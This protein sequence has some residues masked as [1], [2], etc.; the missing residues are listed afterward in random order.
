[1]RGRH[2]LF[3][4]DDRQA[5]FD[6]FYQQMTHG[7]KNDV[8]IVPNAIIKAMD[9]HNTCGVFDTNLN[10]VKSAEIRW[11]HDILMYN[12]DASGIGATPP[13]C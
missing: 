2:I 1:M 6:A 10:P 5:Q 11:T 13:L 12:Q 8:Q 7:R 4:P 9:K 3:M